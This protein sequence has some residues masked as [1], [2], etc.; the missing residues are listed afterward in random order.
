MFLCFRVLI[1]AR[2][3]MPNP[4]EKIGRCNVPPEGGTLHRLFQSSMPN[5]R[6]P[7]I[8]AQSIG[9]N[10]EV[11][12]AAGWR[13]I[14]LTFPIIDARF[15]GNAQSIVKRGRCN[16]PPAGGKLHRL[17]HS[18]MLVFSVLGE[19]LQWKSTQLMRSCHMN[20]HIHA[21]PLISM[22]A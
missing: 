21:Y 5:H 16:L 17:F 15:F 12:F 10:R 8:D 2:S 11:Q 22:D 19:P 6:C 20:I 13:Q 14:A 9:K 4:S 3:S 1:D 7:I 18:S